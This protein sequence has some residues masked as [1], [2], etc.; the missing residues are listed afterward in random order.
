[1]PRTKEP[2]REPLSQLK[3]LEVDYADTPM[4]PRLTMLKMMKESQK[5]PI[6]EIAEHLGVSHRNAMRWWS[7]YRREGLDALLQ[8]RPSGGRRPRRLDDEAMAALQEKLETEGIGTVDEARG[9]LEDRFGVRYSRSGVWYLMRN[10]LGATPRGWVTFHDE[11]TDST[12]RST[13]QST[14]PAG[15]I[16]EHILQFLNGLPVSGGR[17]EMTFALRD[18]LTVL[19]PDVD[20][21]SIVINFECNLTAPESYDPSLAITQFAESTQTQVST[22]SDFSPESHLARLIEGF[23]QDGVPL[24]RYHTPSG[25]EYYFLGKAYLGAIFLWRN[26]EKEPIS[27]VSIALVTSI[28]GFLTYALSD[29]IARDRLERPVGAVFNK[30]LA[31]MKREALLS[32]QEERVAVLQLLGHSYRE[33]A[34]RLYVT[35]DTVKKHFKQIYRKTKTKSQTELFAKYFTTRIAISQDHEADND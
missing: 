34:D 22:S 8:Y 19:L 18:L 9:W 10:S 16:P 13:P 28:A 30:A 31:Q 6:S 25:F 15:A 35:V 5:R 20:R 29:I 23:R 3:K 1:M 2:V 24:D 11:M 17:K 12:P 21:V 32:S 7:T 27:E 26:K 14:L 33:I 4:A